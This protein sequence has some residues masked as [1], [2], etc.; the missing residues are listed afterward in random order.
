MWIITMKRGNKSNQW[1]IPEGEQWT[2][3]ANPQLAT[4][5]RSP[6]RKYKNTW[7]G[8]NVKFPQIYPKIKRNSNQYPKIFKT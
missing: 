4:I 3:I 6:G 8:K 5:L 2:Q 7:F 1:D